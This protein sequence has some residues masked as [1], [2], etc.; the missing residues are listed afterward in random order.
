[1]HIVISYSGSACD[2][3]Y[4]RTTYE[5]KSAHACQSI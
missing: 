5:N 3:N 2:I 1:M 4:K